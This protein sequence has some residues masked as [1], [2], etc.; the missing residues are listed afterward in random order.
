M[1]SA[2]IAAIPGTAGGMFF[3]GFI[4]SR[5]KLKV[6]GLL[7]FAIVTCGISTLF[8]TLVWISCDEGKMAGVNH[9]YKDR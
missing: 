9:P 1:I 6:A 2:G 5:M 8:T 7:K 3:G 4:A